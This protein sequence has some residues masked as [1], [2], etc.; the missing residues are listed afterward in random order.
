MKW[1]V[2][3]EF[4]DPFCSM[5]WTA[6]TQSAF[7]FHYIS[8]HCEHCWNKVEVRRMK[9]EA[10]EVAHAY[11]G[12]TIVHWATHRIAQWL[13]SNKRNADAKMRVPHSSHFR[14]NWI[15]R[16]R[17]L[18]WNNM[19]GEAEQHAQNGTAPWIERER[20]LRAS[21]HERRST[22]KQMCG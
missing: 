11:L 15:Q 20:V 4:I 10:N 22:D 6:I 13:D 3:N 16:R 5:N 21:S 1:K 8:E 17:R 18:T 2:M 9:M 19:D 14:C 12:I 7:R